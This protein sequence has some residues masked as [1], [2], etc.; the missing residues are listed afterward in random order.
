MFHQSS[1]VSSNAVVRNSAF[2]LRPPGN[3]VQEQQQSTTHN[4]SQFYSLNFLEESMSYL[5]RT[6]R[7]LM[8]ILLEIKKRMV[9]EKT[10]REKTARRQRVTK[11]AVE[12]LDSVHE[13][14]M[15]DQDS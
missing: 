14:F 7:K 8:P 6:A 4:L 11:G 9:P 5:E 12:T 1:S 10:V 3:L 15:G 13:D 2:L